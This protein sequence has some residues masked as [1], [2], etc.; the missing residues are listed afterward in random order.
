[1][2]LQRER[3]KRKSKKK[4][5]ETNNN[6]QQKWGAEYILSEEKQEASSLDTKRW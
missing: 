5:T 2:N 1:M 3:G 4:N 6:I